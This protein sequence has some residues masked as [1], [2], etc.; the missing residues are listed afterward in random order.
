[1]RLIISRV[2]RF[3]FGLTFLFAAFPAF[4]QFEEMADVNADSIATA[5]LVAK[6]P[7]VVKNITDKDLAE[8][9]GQMSSCLDLRPT[10][11]VKSY[12]DHYLYRPEKTKRILSKRLT[13]FPVFEEMLKSQ[14]VPDDLKYLSVVESA[15]NPNAV[16]RV[17]ASGL[18]QFMPSTGTDY[19]MQ[20][21]SAVDERNNIVKS[22]ESAARYLKH[23][24]N[25]YNDWAL[26]LAAYNSGPTRVNSA[27][28][29]AG[30]KNFWI[31]Q[32]YLPSETR[33]YVPAFIAATYICNFFN[34]HN[35]EPDY[36]EMDEQILDYITVYDGISFSAIAKAT[37]IEYQ[38]VEDLNPGFKRAYVP[39]SKR[40]YFVTVPKRVMPL[41]VRHLNGLGGNTY[42]VDGNDYSTPS[43]VPG[44]TNYYYST[45]TARETQLLDEFAE[46]NSCN[47]AQLRA[48]NNL[49]NHYVYANQTLRVWH[50]VHLLRHTVEKTEA[51]GSPVKKME[52]PAPVP[53]NVRA[54]PVAAAAGNSTAA[55]KP[56]V[57][58]TR[59]ASA[60]PQKQYLFHKVKDK[61][62]MGDLSRRYG[63]S[64]DALMQLNNTADLKAGML[65]RIKELK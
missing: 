35:L 18:W 4:S 24:F 49:P 13:Y 30:S 36:P 39:P 58:I 40:G 11:V 56:P 16:S 37:G 44:G 64:V 53:S 34:E 57:P 1:M 22:S 63:I 10:K 43:D 8:R 54:N 20:I 45:V 14:G 12:I 60:G 17:G 62:T 51:P 28:R 33:N 5:R 50:P 21:N 23:L 15:L 65:I 29:R 48:W 46:K 6:S 2:S 32:R 42:R 9:L 3:A 7:Y 61:E 47:G 59:P 38:S 31:I 25:Q 55:I 41:L 27:I 26:A 52:S 19:G